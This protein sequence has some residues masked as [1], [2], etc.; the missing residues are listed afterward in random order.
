MRSKS[1]IVIAAG[2]LL[3]LL[4]F[5]AWIVGTRIGDVNPIS[6][7]GSPATFSD[8]SLNLQGGIGSPAGGDGSPLPVLSKGMPKF[9]GIEAWLNSS[10]LSQEDLRGK[11]VLVD[12]WTYSCINCI[13]TLPYVTSWYDKYEDDGLVVIGVHT[14][15]FAFEKEE[16]NVKRAIAEHGIR[17]PVALDNDYGTWTAYANHY[18]PAHYLFDAQGRLRDTHFGEGAYDET[19]AH[20]VSLLEEAGY[21]PDEEMTE[22][23]ALPDFRQI[24]S[25]ETYVGYGRMTSLGSPESVLPDETGSYTVADDPER[26]FFYF[27]GKWR[28][29]KERAVAAGE[30]S[31]IV[32]R[33]RASAANLVMGPPESGS[34]RVK[35]TVDGVETQ[36]ITVDA[37]TLYVLHSTPGEYGEHVL[38]LE[39]LDPGTSAYAFT[40]G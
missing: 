7:S 30:G 27:G 39:F 38:E 34:G 28:V 23:G 6:S 33:Y 32:Y 19:E 14:P 40:F 22:V 21:S 3:G 15:E 29:E 13:R 37:E 18:W 12:F 35:V 16:A 36:V 11:V 5:A 8:P 2:I 24:G 31:K 4:V 9:V 25:P 20:I 1:D 26:N 17:Y 10:P